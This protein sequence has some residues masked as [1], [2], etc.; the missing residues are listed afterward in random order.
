M[1]RLLKMTLNRPSVVLMQLRNA[2][3]IHRSTVK[4]LPSL[5]VFPKLKWNI[6]HIAI[7]KDYKD[8]PFDTRFFRFQMSGSELLNYRHWTQSVIYR[9]HHSLCANWISIWYTL[10]IRVK[11]IRWQ[12]TWQW[13]WREYIHRMPDRSPWNSLQW[14]LTPESATY[15]WESRGTIQS[16]DTYANRR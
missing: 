4:S 13:N 12:T 7:W 15:S 6:L 8:G 2:F 16:A 9:A 14:G 11:L 1:P 10:L 3:L 5:R